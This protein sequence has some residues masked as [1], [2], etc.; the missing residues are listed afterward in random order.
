MCITLMSNNLTYFSIPDKHFQ[1]TYCSII[2]NTKKSETCT[3]ELKMEWVKSIW[4]IHATEY[5]FKKWERPLYAGIEQCPKVIVL[6]RNRLRK[7]HTRLFHLYEKT[8]QSKKI[9]I[10]IC[11]KYIKGSIQNLEKWKKNGNYFFYSYIL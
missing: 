11:L 5:C 3:C 1:K 7:I 8:P 10:I 6:W 2:C 4:Y 9:H